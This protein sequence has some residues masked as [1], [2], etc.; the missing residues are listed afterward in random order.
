V[1]LAGR[2]CPRCPQNSGFDDLK[3]AASVVK[4]AELADAA[5]AKAA[6]FRQ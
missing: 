2:V 1:S 4:E 5:C 3:D 6:P